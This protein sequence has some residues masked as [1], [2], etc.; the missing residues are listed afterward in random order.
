MDAVF[1]PRLLQLFNRLVDEGYAHFVVDLS[2][3]RV[4]EADGDYP[5]L[6]LLKEV[7]P[8]RDSSVVLVCPAMNP[9][10]IL[11][12][13]TRLDTLFEMAESLE[14]ALAGLSRVTE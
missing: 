11:Y 4:L 5:L 8:Y 3:V 13:L 10:R 14:G 9:V 12:E 2:D 6:H 1:A 7:Q